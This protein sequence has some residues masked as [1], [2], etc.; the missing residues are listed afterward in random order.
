[1][2]KKLLPITIGI[3][4]N[5]ILMIVFAITTDGEFTRQ[6]KWAGEFWVFVLVMLIFPAINLVLGKKYIL[7]GNFLGIAVYFIALVLIITFL[8]VFFG[9]RG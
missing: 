9:Y 3:L 8:T 5:F 6:Y 7:L 1:M 4:E 2:N